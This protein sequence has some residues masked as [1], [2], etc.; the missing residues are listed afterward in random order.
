ML[1]RVMGSGEKTWTD[2]R[3]ADLTRMWADGDSAGQIAAA[4]GCFGHCADGGRSA[5]LGKITRLNLPPRLVEF[6]Q[7]PH[8]EITKQERAER[9]K[10]RAERETARKEERRQAQAARRK[11][12]PDGR[13][14]PLVI[15]PKPMPGEFLAIAFMDLQP[16]Q[17]RYPQGGD[18]APTFFCGQP[19]V[20]GESWCSHC[21]KIVFSQSHHLTEQGRQRMVAHG[22]KMT[23]P[24]TDAIARDYG[25]EATA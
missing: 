20:P 25:D 8:R 19:V 7:P 24:A 4:L 21:H 2:E 9:A 3:V 11:R 12:L 13:L 5:V 18:G 16:G 17:C 10:A 15:A 22:R 1:D 23:K 6:R 14:P